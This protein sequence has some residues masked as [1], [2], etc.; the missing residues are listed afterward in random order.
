MSEN[1]L[2]LVRKA[3]DGNRAAFDQLVRRSV[4]RVFGIIHRFFNERQVVEDLA[5]EAFIKAYTALASYRQERPFG[6][7]LA[8]ITVRLCYQELRK[9]RAR[10][11]HLESEL[12]PDDATALDGFCTVY[13]DTTRPGP[14]KQA[15]LR[16]LTDKVLD[17]LSPR[18]RMV[19]VLTEVEGLSVKEVAEMLGMTRINVKVSNHRARK[20]ALKILLTLSQGVKS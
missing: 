19:L 18:E 9:R 7:W 17:R 2:E 13:A 4:P 16:D 15:Q 12:V 20:H 11:E 1:D 5:Q 8:V 6:N 3:L 10:K 14:E